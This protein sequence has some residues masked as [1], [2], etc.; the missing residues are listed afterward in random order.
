MQ[1]DISYDMI[2]VGAG[3]GG[4]TVA[5]KL[6]NQGF[7][8]L[9]AD[10]NKTAGGK[11]MTVR[12][13]GNSY[14]LWPVAGGPSRPSRFDELIDLIGLERDIVI[15]PENVADFI[16]LAPDGTRRHVHF[17]ATRPFLKIGKAELTQTR[18]DIELQKRKKPKKKKKKEI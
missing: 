5:A 10:R 9:I 14:E 12:K 17:P 13:D 1:A 11:A 4:V 18:D 6:A 2:V 16:Y 8:V 7:R 3:Y 15:R